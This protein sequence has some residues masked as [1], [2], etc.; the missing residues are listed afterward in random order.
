MKKIFIII[1][2]S[3]IHTQLIAED[4]KDFQIEGLSIG[5]SALDH[6]DKKKIIDSPK[7]NY[8]K[9]TKFSNHAI[10]V[11]KTSKLFD[12]LV[13]AFKKN[14]KRYIIHAISGAVYYN[15]DIDKCYKKRNE[16]I[17]EVDTLFPT[18]QTKSYTFP[19][20]VDVSGKSNARIKDY[21]IQGGDIRVWCTDWSKNPKVKNRRDNLQISIQTKEFSNWIKN[22]AY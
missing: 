18:A 7:I 14:D 21:Y 17:E 15:D 22:E 5:D 6:F 8:E 2:L 3:L 19:Y 12:K 20:P 13:I 4:I 10:D 11:K 9:S 1:I 16:I